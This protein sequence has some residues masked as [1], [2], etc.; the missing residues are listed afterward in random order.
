[1]KVLIIIPAYNEEKN[2]PFIYNTLKNIINDNIEIILVNNGSTDNSLKILSQYSWIEIREFDTE[3]T[4]DP[5]KISQYKSF[6]YADAIGK[7]DYVMVC[8]ID[9][10]LLPS[11]NLFPELVLAKKDN[12]QLFQTKYY[13]IINNELDTKCDSLIHT[14]DGYYAYP[15]TNIHKAIVFDPQIKIAFGHN[16]LTYSTNRNYNTKSI[17]T[18]HLK[19]ISSNILVSR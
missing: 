7:A 8:D 9:E 19:M 3:N 1:M 2:I 4:F 16:S 13:E 6:C 10:V 15:N 18:L 11:E 12:V 5:E 14:A 17:I